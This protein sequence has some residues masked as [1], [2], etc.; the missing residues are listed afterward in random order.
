MEWYSYLVE[1][2]AGPVVVAGA[3]AWLLNRLQHQ[4]W[5]TRSLV[6]L[7]NQTY[8][9]ANRILVGSIRSLTAPNAEPPHGERTSAPESFDALSN[10]VHRLF[11]RPA[12]QAVADAVAAILRVRATMGD[13]TIVAEELNEDAPDVNDI[14]ARGLIADA[15]FR[16]R[17]SLDLLAASIGQ[18]PPGVGA[19]IKDKLAFG[20]RHDDDGGAYSS[21]ARP[22]PRH[23]KSRRYTDRVWDSIERDQTRRQ[24]EPEDP[25]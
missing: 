14:R 7:Q 13:R 6:E 15:I 17:R 24:S 23:D 12:S 20:K 3:S 11:P 22:T 10:E 18:G 19:R 8:R 1:S 9:D 4:F 21:I 2:I 16:T 25:S 5:K